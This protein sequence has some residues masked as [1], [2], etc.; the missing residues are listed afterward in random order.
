MVIVELCINLRYLWV[1]CTGH[2]RPTIIA[3]THAIRHIM[4]SNDLKNRFLA[5]CQIS[6][7][8]V[9][10]RVTPLQKALVRFAAF[11]AKVSI[12]NKRFVFNIHTQIVQLAK[13]SNMRT[14]AIGDGG[15]DVNMIQVI[16][17]CFDASI[18]RR[19]KQLPCVCI[20][21]ST[22]RCRH[23]RSRRPASSTCCRLQCWQWVLHTHILLLFSLPTFGF[24]NNIPKQKCVE[25]NFTT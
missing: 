20:S 10:C 24:Q 3:T 22:H 12:A 8:V 4:N 16:H 13:S 11:L 7:C 15:N 14:L 23:R 19:N 21:G 18:Q 17:F 2:Q 1:V 6:E 5:L 9:C 25:Q